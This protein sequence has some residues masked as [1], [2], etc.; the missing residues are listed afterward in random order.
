MSTFQSLDGFVWDT[1]NEQ[2]IWLKHRISIREAEQPFFNVYFTEPDTGHS[3]KEQRFT[4]IGVT[5]AAKVLF[6]VFTLTSK[7]IRIISARPA[8]KKERLLYEQAIKENPEV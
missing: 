1:A 5:N 3:Q 8:S 4:L 6:I 2:K 7:R